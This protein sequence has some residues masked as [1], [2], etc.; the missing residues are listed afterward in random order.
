[1]E[2]GPSETAPELAARMSELG[3]PLMAETLRGLAAGS[4]VARPQD[5]SLASSAPMLKREDGRIKWSRSAQEI[6]NR[7]R[8]FAPWPGAYTAFRGLTCHVWGEP[9]SN[10][11]AEQG[12]AEDNSAVP[13]TLMVH[14]NEILACCGGATHLRVRAVKLEGRRQVSAV[15]FANGVHLHTGEHFGET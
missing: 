4:L 8:G 11:L 7:I 6:Y 13:G 3:A 9:V 5:H 2:I 10:N 1:M 14:R 15:D 12:P